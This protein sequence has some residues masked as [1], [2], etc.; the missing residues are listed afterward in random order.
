M[1]AENGKEGLNIVFSWNR[2]KCKL[3]RVEG[4][5]HKSVIIVLQL[6]TGSCCC[7]VLERFP[8]CWFHFMKIRT[9]SMHLLVV[10]KSDPM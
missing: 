4:R 5:Q 1:T 7:E 2:I 9:F 3:V 6:A 8:R 10:S